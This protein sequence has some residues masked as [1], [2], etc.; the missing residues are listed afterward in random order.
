MFQQGGG[1]NRDGIHA[2]SLGAASEVRLMV[3]AGP[4][5]LADADGKGEVGKRECRTST[6]RS[7]MEMPD[8]RLEAATGELYLAV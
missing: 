3:V 8:V 5:A 2:T 1:G 7:P 4:L 6:G